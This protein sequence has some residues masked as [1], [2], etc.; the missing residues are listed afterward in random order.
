MRCLADLVIKNANIITMDQDLPRAEAIAIRGDRI[1]AVGDDSD[2]EGLIGPGTEIQDLK[3]LTVMPGF[4]DNHGHPL[5]FAD[6]LKKVD[7]TGSRSIGEMFDRLQKKAS[8]LKPGDWI[9]GFGYDETLFAEEREPTF[10]EMNK[11]F[12]DN[13]IYV[14]R[15][16]LHV[17]L[18]NEL[19]HAWR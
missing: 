16:C 18:G 14:V 2:V 7:C 8:E 11:A 10:E 6:S 19:S 17:A 4:N 5:Y 12:P 13:P 15:A 9:Q 1:L 3:G